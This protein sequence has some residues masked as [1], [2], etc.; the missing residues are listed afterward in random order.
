MQVNEIVKIIKCESININ[1]KIRPDQQFLAISYG[2]QPLFV[3]YNSYEDIPAW[4]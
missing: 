2:I 4:F 3:I 1:L